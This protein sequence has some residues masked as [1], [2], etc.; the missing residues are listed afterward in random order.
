MRI[1]L[2]SA[3][4]PPCGGIATWTTKYIDYCR[5]H[6]IAYS[7]VNI[8]LTG[9]R[10]TQVNRRRN[11]KDEI[12][13]TYSIVKQVG[14]EVKSANVDVMHINTSCGQFGLFRD[15]LCVRKAAKH[16]IP[17][18]LHCHCNVQDQI[19]SKFC[20]FVLKKMSGLSRCILVLNQK[21]LSYMQSIT[22]TE[23]K[24]IPNFIEDSLIQ[25]KHE[26]S[27]T[28]CSVLFVGHVQPAKGVPEIFEAAKARK[29]IRFILVGPVKDTF[30]STEF[31]SN[32]TLVGK[33]SFDE[34]RAFYD[35]AD[36]YLFPSHSEGFSLSLLEAMA[37]GL[38]CIATD[39]GA[40]KDMIEP[41]GGIVIQAGCPGNIVSALDRLSDRT[42]REKMSQ[43]NIETVKNRYRLD[44][45]M[46]SMMN[47]YQEILRN[48]A[49]K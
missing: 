18:V 33:K 17:V 1:L 25:S 3:I 42:I 2:V 47:I 14:K 8:A 46:R 23:T 28:I 45:V 30:A 24:I 13:R 15:Y 29:D 21:S 16:G 35:E 40:N 37:A 10:I 43:W 36:V 38:P 49:S 4:P 32:V 6:H 44:F 31:P 11:L 22:S 27:D 12:F 39:V 41:G 19:R 7:L 48:S 9:D 20:A 26:I 5:Q 34:V